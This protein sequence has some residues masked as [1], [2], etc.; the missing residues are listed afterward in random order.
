[1]AVSLAGGEVGELPQRARRQPEG[2]LPG[3]GVLLRAE[4][5]EEV[6]VRVRGVELHQLDPFGSASE[7]LG[8]FEGQVGL[9]R[10]R[11]AV[12]HQLP[13]VPEEVLHLAQPLHVVDEQFVGEGLARLGKLQLTPGREGRDRLARVA[14]P[15]HGLVGELLVGTAESVDEGLHGGEVDDVVLRRELLLEF[16]GKLVVGVP[17]ALPVDGAAQVGTAAFG[18]GLLDRSGDLTDVQAA[19]GDA[20]HRVARLH[21]GEERV[22]LVDELQLLVVGRRRPVVLL[23]ERSQPLLA[24]P[25]RHSLAQP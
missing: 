22:Q 13:F 14:F 17:A 1:M 25:L 24:R 6:L 7:E 9:A 12:Q 19:P 2:D 4:P 5:F 16:L 3:V 11:R 23:D 15:G 20:T 18:G 8:E 10:A 21:P